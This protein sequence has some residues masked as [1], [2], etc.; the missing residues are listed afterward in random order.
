MIQA[1]LGLRPDIKI[2]GTDY[3]TP[4]GTC[5]R[6]YVHVTDLCDAHMLAIDRLTSGDKGRAYNLGNGQGFCVREVIETVREVSGRSF[7]V[8]ETVHRPG[9]PGVLVADASR[10]K[11]ALSWS[12][13]R[14]RLSQIV[15]DAWNFD[16]QRSK[17]W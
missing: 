2:Y 12:P 7:K 16:R 17:K 4:D 6:D 3:E 13:R 14:D 9:D 15:C 10:A 11:A 8:V 5:V 1:A